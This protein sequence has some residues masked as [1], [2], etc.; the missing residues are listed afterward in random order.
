[1][2]ER[3]DRRVP[4]GGYKAAVLRMR[5]AARCQRVPNRTDQG[6][7]YLY[8]VYEPAALTR[9]STLA[10]EHS[11]RV[12]WRA[13]WERLRSEGVRKV[14]AKTAANGR[15]RLK[16]RAPAKKVRHPRTYKQRCLK[17][18]PALACRHTLVGQGPQTF[19]LYVV[20]EGSDVLAQEAS[21]A[22]AWEAA[23]REMSR[24]KGRRTTSRPAVDKTSK[25]RDRSGTTYTGQARKLPA[26][27]ARHRKTAKAEALKLRPGLRC[28]RGDRDG[29]AVLLPDEGLLPSPI[30]TRIIARGSSSQ[31]AWKAA[32][33]VLRDDSAASTGGITVK[34]TPDSEGVKSIVREVIARPDYA[35]TGYS[36]EEREAAYLIGIRARTSSRD[37]Y[38]EP[39]TRVDGEPTMWRVVAGGVVARVLSTDPT[40]LGALR[41]ALWLSWL[42]EQDPDT[43]LRKVASGW[44]EYERGLLE[45][46][47]ETTRRNAEGR[48]DRETLPVPYAP[49]PQPHPAPKVVAALWF[50]LVVI[51]AVAG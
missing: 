35:E 18:R 28:I 1:M 23:Y 12:A 8:R 26:G 21:P 34:Q 31:A 20:S 47:R 4:K 30:L 14:A 43:P 37:V 38:V 33:E 9:G 17:L 39:C 19:S 32:L 29:Y 46:Y 44:I 13:A 2:A 11:P 7:A 40:R 48:E 41:E 25:K 24:D 6:G 10:T 51:M 27:K 45:K 15:R 50:L 36:D 16:V 42:D 3:S 5:P 22:K 49:P